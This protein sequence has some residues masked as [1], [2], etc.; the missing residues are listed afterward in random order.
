MIVA[1]INMTTSAGFGRDGFV[2]RV[3]FADL[4]AAKA[5]Y[6]RIAKLMLDKEERKNDLPKMVEVSGVGKVTIPLDSI[7][8]VGLEDFAWANEQLAGM[9]DAYPNLRKPK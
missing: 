7:C 4:D 9:H 6:E 2:H 3:D 5:E 8:S 1:T